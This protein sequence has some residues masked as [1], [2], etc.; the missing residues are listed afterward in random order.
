[1]ITESQK[2]M[3]WILIEDCFD[4]SPRECGV[5]E[6]DK[7]EHFF[8]KVAEILWDENK[9]A[10]IRWELSELKHDLRV[11]ADRIGDVC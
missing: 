7:I 10:D 6:R 3:L 1:M 11:T 9:I 8:S 4:I 5:K 2:S